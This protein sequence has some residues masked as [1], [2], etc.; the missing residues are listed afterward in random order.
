MG[1]SKNANCICPSHQ[2][3]GAF[4][5]VQELEDNVPFLVDQRAATLFIAVCS[6]ERVAFLPDH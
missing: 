1:Y 6:V 2:L 5:Y 3:P 4:C